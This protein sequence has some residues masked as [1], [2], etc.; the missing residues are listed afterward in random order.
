MRRSAAAALA[1]VLVALCPLLAVAQT[2]VSACGQT[3]ANG[4][5]INDL[6]C[7]SSSVPAVTVSP[8][9]Q[10]DL[11]GF[12]IHAGAGGGVYCEA[13]CFVIGREG[14]ILGLGVEG[15][16]LDYAPGV[17][18]DG[19]ADGMSTRHLLIITRMEISGFYGQAIVGGDLQLEHLVL[20]ESAWNSSGRNID[21]TATTSATRFTGRR[22]EVSNSTFSAE[23][24]ARRV[25]LEDT[26]VTGADNY[27][28]IG[29][30]LRL[31]RSTVTGNCVEGTAS[32]CADIASRRRPNLRDS[33]CG[34]SRNIH[35]SG[36]AKPYVSWGV[37]END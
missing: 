35:N 21:I 1:I 9:G 13:D 25:D 10:L 8:G 31:D 18:T 26:V 17:F 15:S 24:N 34:T 20:G 37:C 4:V 36:G 27:G 33:V 32:P 23:L 30:F 19:F 28:V 14:A 29:R 3:V 7:S 16:P 12:T 11:A 6:D 22:I 2:S 5:L